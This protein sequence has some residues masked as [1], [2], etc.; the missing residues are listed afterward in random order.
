MDLVKLAT[1]MCPAGNFIDVAIAVQMMEPCISVRLKAALEALQMLP[2]MLALAILRVREPDR[3]SGV[4]PGRPVVAHIG[5]EP[6]GFSLTSARG[7]HRHR[8]V[9]GVKLV[10][11]QHVLLN[12]VHQRREQLACST[13]PARQRGALDG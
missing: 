3:R 5:P 11:C 12:R 10:A 13:Y 1:C 8:G 4:F 2:W 6:S 9:V 7:K